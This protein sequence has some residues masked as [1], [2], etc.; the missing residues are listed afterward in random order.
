MLSVKKLGTNTLFWGL[1]TT[2]VQLQRFT[3]DIDAW[4]S[5]TLDSEKCGN[6][7]IWEKL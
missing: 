4:L 6:F 5:R 3:I 1:K 7:I 2:K